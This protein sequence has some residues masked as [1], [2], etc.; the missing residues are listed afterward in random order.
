MRGIQKVNIE[1][2]MIVAGQN[3]KRLIKHRLKKLVSLTQN[4]VSQL[5]PTR[6]F[7]FSTAWNLVC[8]LFIKI[9]HIDFYGLFRLNFR[10]NQV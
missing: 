4:L 6:A 8:H 10:I 9:D 3:L 7:T 5:I 2:V 1:G